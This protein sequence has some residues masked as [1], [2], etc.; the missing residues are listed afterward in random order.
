MKERICGVLQFPEII[1]SLIQ[2]LKR[3]FD[4]FLNIRF[5]TAR[6]HEKNF[7]TNPTRKIRTLKKR[8]KVNYIMCLI[9]FYSYRVLPS[10]YMKCQV[11]STGKSVSISTANMIS[12][13]K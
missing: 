5:L 8:K 11:E 9:F 3:C 7:K 13:K 2:A 12:W 1:K 6:S 4:L 10:K